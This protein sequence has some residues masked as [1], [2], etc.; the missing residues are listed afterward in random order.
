MTAP[1]CPSCNVE[2]DEGFLIDR[3]H[4]N[5]PSQ[6]EWAQGA[7]EHSW[8]QGIK[9]KGRERLKTM[10]YRCPKCGLLQSYAQTSR[11]ES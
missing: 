2:M 11:E 3:G 1:N 9:L 4:L 10:T 8:W 6:N 5:A 7:V